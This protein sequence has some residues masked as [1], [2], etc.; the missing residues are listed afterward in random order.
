MNQNPPRKP[1]TPTEADT[2]ALS[3][4]EEIR[5]RAYELY[6]K[7]GREDGLAWDD[8]HQAEAEISQKRSRAA[9][10]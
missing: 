4:E 6:E 8:W 7:R 1:P 3:L 2:A 9:A 5:C 10:D